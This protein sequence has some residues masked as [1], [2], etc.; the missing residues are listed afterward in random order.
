MD[1]LYLT[2]R[3]G[4]NKDMDCITFNKTK[5]WYGC[6]WYGHATKRYSDEEWIMVVGEQPVI[7][8]QWHQFENDDV[9]IAFLGEKKCEK[10]IWY[11]KIIFDLD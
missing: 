8:T 6:D 3:G 1:N 2:Q 10:N 5:A 7:E 11:G 4:P 9:E